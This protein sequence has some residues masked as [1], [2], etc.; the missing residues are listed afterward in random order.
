MGWIN[1]SFIVL[2]PSVFDD[3]EGDGNILVCEPLERVAGDSEL[4]AFKHSG[5]RR[6]M[7]M[8]RD[9]CEVAGLWSGGRASLKRW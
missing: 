5:S 9:K 2:E 6:P 8:L 3:I 1:G 7:D 4:T